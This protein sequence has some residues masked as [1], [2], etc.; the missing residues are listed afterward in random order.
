MN[1][2]ELKLIIEDLRANGYYEL[3]DTDGNRIALCLKVSD[4][5]I[6]VS[7]DHLKFWE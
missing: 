2:N 1:F 4:E 5:K 3:V 6:V 7:I